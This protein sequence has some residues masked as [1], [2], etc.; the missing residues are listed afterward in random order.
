MERCRDWRGW[1]SL[2]GVRREGR[3]E[4]CCSGGQ[5]QP[6]RHA[7]VASS[8]STN[9]SVMN[10]RMFIGAVAAQGIVAARLP[11][12]GKPRHRSDASAVLDTRWS[13]TSGRSSRRYY[14]APLRALGWVQSRNPAR[15]TTLRQQQ[16]RTSPALLR[17][18]SSFGSQVEII[19]TEGHGR[20]AGG[21]RTP[22]PP[23]PIVIHSAGDPIRCGS[24]RELAPPGSNI[25]GYSIIAPEIER[26]AHCAWRELLP[27]LPSASAYWSVRLNPYYRAVRNEG[28][29]RRGG[30]LA[31][32]RSSSKLLRQA[33]WRMRSRSLLANGCRRAGY[34]AMVCSGTNRVA[35][36]SAALRYAFADPRV[37]RGVLAAGALV[38]YVHE[39]VRSKTNAPPHF[40]EQNPPWCK[41]RR[42][43]DR[44]AD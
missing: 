11:R 41:A 28:S 15:P 7:T 43:P 8:Y 24:R 34:K 27:G 35:L 33:S 30:H 10:R 2:V 14:Y 23:Y 20:R 29:S 18:R 39:N 12:P 21:T 44:A 42:S 9:D 31:R 25:T 37:R 22:R 38:P 26:K 1:T 40:V 19:V 32:S 17:R 36:M 13:P 3:V 4:A 6:A 5:A 16:S